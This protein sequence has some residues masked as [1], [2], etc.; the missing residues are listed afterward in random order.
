MAEESVVRV[1]TNKGRSARAWSRKSMLVRCAASAAP[2]EWVEDD[3]TIIVAVRVDD[4]SQ[5]VL[6]LVMCAL[7]SEGSNPNNR[8]TNTTMDTK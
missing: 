7:P 3:T 5:W 2:R 1:P 4:C 8:A 6:S